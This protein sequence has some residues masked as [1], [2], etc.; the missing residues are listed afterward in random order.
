MPVFIF[1]HVLAMFTAVTISYGPQ[2]LLM[3]AADRNDPVALQGLARSMGR[4]GQFMGPAFVVGLILGLIAVFV[5]NFNPLA[6]WL[7][8]AYVLFAA[9]MLNG[10]FGTGRWMASVGQTAAASG[11]VMTDELRGL[12]DQST[13]RILLWAD[14][15]LVVLIIADMVLKPLS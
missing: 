13:I 2:L 14:I 12:L 9:A 3:M 10:I 1:L 15:V 7:L 4:L 8:I 11:G 5:N 6:P